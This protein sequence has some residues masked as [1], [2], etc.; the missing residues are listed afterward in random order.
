VVEFFG[1]SMWSGAL[2]QNAA[3]RVFPLPVKAVPCYKAAV[4]EF[5]GSSMWSRA[6][7]TK[8]CGTEFSAIRVLGG[9]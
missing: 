9:V 4:V 2:L 1:S 7:V 5:F 8:R 3:T 6:F